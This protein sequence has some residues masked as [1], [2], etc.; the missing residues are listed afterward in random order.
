MY[1][2]YV[3]SIIFHATIYLAHNSNNPGRAAVC[4]NEVLSKVKA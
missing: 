4:N 3:T 1:F 2:L